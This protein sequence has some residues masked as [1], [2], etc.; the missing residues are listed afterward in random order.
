[1]EKQMKLLI[2]FWIMYCAVAASVVRSQDLPREV[3]VRHDLMPNSTFLFD[4]D[5]IEYR[6]RLVAVFGSRLKVRGLSE[7]AIL[8]EPSFEPETLIALR[9]EGQRCFVMAA[10]A[11]RQVYHVKVDEQVPLTRDRKKEIDP[12]VAVRVCDAVRAMLMRTHYQ[13][14]DV[15]HTDGVSYTYIAWAESVGV[16]IGESSNP[17]PGTRVRILANVSDA[18]IAFVDCEESKQ[19]EAEA[20]LANALAAME[21][22]L[23][24]KVLRK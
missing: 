1:M 2:V 23:A 24:D 14:T 3:K 18:L 8:F 16:M 13:Y 11:A 20:S 19:K 21:V 17:M 6:K 7:V 4:E 15:G 9:K 10:T 22:A 12:K 5:N